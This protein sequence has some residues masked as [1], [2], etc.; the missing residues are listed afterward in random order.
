MWVEGYE[1]SSQVRDVE[2]RVSLGYKDCGCQ[3]VAF[4][5][6]V[7]GNLTLY[8]GQNGMEVEQKNQE[9][10]GAFTVANLN[11]TDNDQKD[12]N[13]P[14]DFTKVGPDA[15]DDFVTVSD[16][17]H[18]GGTDGRDEIDLMKL[19]ID[20]PAPVIEND[21]LD[22]VV[23]GGTARFWGTSHKGTG[24]P[25][26]ATTL[27]YDPNAIS[28]PNWPRE[29]WV[30]LPLASASLRDVEIVSRY[31][32]LQEIDVV[33]A[34]GIWITQVDAKHDAADP[35]DPNGL[36]GW[37]DLTDPPRNWLVFFRGFGLRPIN[38]T[39]GVRNT[40]G[41]RFQLQPSGIW[42]EPSVYFDISRSNEDRTWYRDPNN[43]WH[44]I[45]NIRDW[46]H[47]PEAANDDPPAE[48]DESIDPNMATGGF[49]AADGPGLPTPTANPG[50]YLSLQFNFAEFVRVGFTS[51][52]NDN[53]CHGSRCSEYALW[54]CRHLL[55]EVGG[56]RTRVGG[57]NES[58][59]NCVDTGNQ[60]LRVPP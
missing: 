6:V 42:R 53:G 34:T 13:D 21:A 37:P 18:P 57:D 31:A 28:D 26:G 45:A 2:F 35:N 32:G 30:E 47:N 55:Q 56:L 54:H 60:T 9:K 22:V 14:N 36:F 3:D 59:E 58:A 51:R 4:L 17:N 52:P 25:S 11:D 19:L 1:T 49:F 41:L 39:N 27:H 20:R 23:R 38:W 15:D 46:P 24:T 8:Y 16:P 50:E 7:E 5:T 10:H 29:V 40:I 43:Q 12:V 33:K 48:G 44:L